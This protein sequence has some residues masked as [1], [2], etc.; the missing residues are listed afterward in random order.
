MLSR[1][2]WSIPIAA[3]AV[4]G[5]WL[6]MPVEFRDRTPRSVVPDDQ[7]HIV[8]QPEF[9]ATQE[10]NPKSATVSERE[11]PRSGWA[12]GP[13]SDGESLKFRLETTAELAQVGG[14]Q[15]ALMLAQLALEDEEP[16]VRMEALR[17]L[18][19]L[20]GDPGDVQVLEQALWDPD[21][22]VRRTALEA[23]TEVGSQSS[24]PV[25]SLLLTDADPAL[26]TDALDAVV[27]M[28][29]ELAIGVLQQAL[30]DEDPSIR[31]LAGDYLAALSEADLDRP[32][33]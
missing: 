3:S 4:V 15:A 10:P 22:A 5:I 2:Q 1:L 6:A 30:G 25:L 18:A 12:W 27:H 23:L 20:G 13:V 21:R 9:R 33:P 24:V 31:D 32:A 29:G 16:R 7:H 17:G 26:R 28:G 14:P 11:S 19:D 8:E